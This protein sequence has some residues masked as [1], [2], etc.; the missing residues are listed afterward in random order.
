M[1]SNST[2]Q[3]LL[4]YLSLL[5]YTP[6]FG[7]QSSLLI[8]KHEIEEFDIV[9]SIQFFLGQK[10]VESTSRCWNAKT[11]TV[12]ESGWQMISKSNHF[13]YWPYEVGQVSNM[14]PLPAYMAL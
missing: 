9:N 2:Q 6:I 11:K 3:Y 10:K 5:I 8:K 7:P 4:K 13:T 14:G 1:D 12:L